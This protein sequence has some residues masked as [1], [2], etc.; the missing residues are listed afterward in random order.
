MTWPKRLAFVGL[1]LVNFALVLCGVWF[2]MWTP[3]LFDKGSTS[4]KGLVAIAVSILLFPVVALICAFLPWLFLL[5]RWRR[6]A[7]VTAILPVAITIA[8]GVALVVS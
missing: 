4:D 8:S 7:L 2:A 6:V 5:F 3:M 1:T